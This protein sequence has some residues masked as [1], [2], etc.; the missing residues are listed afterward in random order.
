MTVYSVL[1][2]VEHG[3][4]IENILKDNPDLPREAV[5]AALV[6]AASH[7]LRGRPSGR[8]WVRTG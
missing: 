6:F 3:E 8:P 1:G 7:P 4:T 5:E 2:R